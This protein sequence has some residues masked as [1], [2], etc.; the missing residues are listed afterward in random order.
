[1]HAKIGDLRPGRGGEG[2]AQEDDQQHRLEQ[3]R[4]FGGGVFKIALPVHHVRHGQK[5]RLDGDAAH[6]VRERIACIAACGGADRHH[7][8]RQRRRPAQ[9]HGAH[10]RLAQRGAVGDDIGQPRGRDRGGDD[11]CARGGK[12]REQKRKGKRGDHRKE[13]SPDRR[14]SKSTVRPFRNLAARGPP[15]GRHRRQ[16]CGR[17]VSIC[18][19]QASPSQ[20]SQSTS[21]LAISGSRN[22]AGKASKYARPGILYQRDSM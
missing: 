20:V 1:M 9:D 5:Q 15:C 16:W 14:V 13:P 2:Q 4:R 3:V 10:H 21:K 11:N 8:A 17:A 12:N 6:P 18:A 7:G 22:R 19:G